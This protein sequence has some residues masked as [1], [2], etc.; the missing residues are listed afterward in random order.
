MVFDLCELGAKLWEKRKTDSGER[1]LSSLG[2]EEAKY[3]KAVLSLLP[4]SDLTEYGEDFF[5]EDLREA[6]R[7]REEFPWCRELSERDFFLY[8]LFPRVNDEEL[9]HCRGF[10]RELL[11]PRVKGLSLQD[12]I[13]E[14]NRFCA[15]QVTYRSTDGR[16]LSAL[17]VYSRGYGR[18]GEETLFAVNVL[19]SVGIAARQVY[20]PLWSHCDDNHAWVECFDSERWRYFGA[21]EPEPVLDCGWFTPAASRAMAVRTKIFLP[22]EE[23]EI[24]KI[25]DEEI[26]VGPGCV[27]PL[28]TGRYAKVR[29]VKFSVMDGPSPLP[30]EKIML[31]ILND[32]AYLPIGEK[33]CDSHGNAVILLGFG[34]ALVRAEKDGRFIAEKLLGPFE[35][36]MVLKFQT[37][38]D[39][40]EDYDFIAPAGGGVSGLT[41]ELKAKRESILKEAEKKRRERIS[42]KKP[43]LSGK[44]AMAFSALSEKDRAGKP[45]F[46]VLSDAIASFAYENDF[47]GEVF[48]SGILSERIGREPLKPWREELGKVLGKDMKRQISQKP[49]TAVSWVFNN[50]SIES[51]SPVPVSLIS[52][53]RRGKGDIET[54]LSLA[55]AALRVSGIPARLSKEGEIEIYSGSGFSR[56]VLSEDRAGLNLSAKAGDICLMGECNRILTRLKSGENIRLSLP[57]GRYRLLSASRLPSGNQLV[58]EV[59]FTLSSGEERNLSLSARKAEYKNLLTR[60]KLPVFSFKGLSG[61][62]ETPPEFSVLCFLKPDREPTEHLL[63]ELMEEETPSLSP[64]FLV[65][66]RDEASDGLLNL[67]LKKYPGSAV[68][69]FDMAECEEAARACFLEPDVFPLC[70]IMDRGFCR[71]AVSGYRVG[72]VSLL[73][74]MAEEARE[75]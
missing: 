25:P 20:T 8:V 4:E 9:C 34:S 44:H 30:K 74:H 15:E 24:L 16:T 28:L 6:L 22:N 40:A 52:A 50:F 29:K 58:R 61:E 73:S 12:A 46:E 72:S 47:P 17:E 37:S 55:V 2:T 3:L 23:R 41:Q 51:P 14:A 67:V 60:F 39:K 32:G 35:E 33:E 26:L 27:Y 1:L 43:T 54:L 7:A 53:L 69:L 38:W 11:A 64:V 59:K 21:C 70:L 71:F 56:L 48:T 65:N 62:A 18:C 19:R 36:E 68:W 42:E 49:E 75:I 45:R 66:D 13:L 57:P 31:Y 5:L 10:F 63:N